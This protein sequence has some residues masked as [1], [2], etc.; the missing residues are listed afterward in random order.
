MDNITLNTIIKKFDIE[1]IEKHIIYLYLLAN[2]IDYKSNKF[3]TSYF[4]GFIVSEEIQTDIQ[5]LN[6][7][8]LEELAVDMEL[9]IPNNDRVVNGA[10]FTP[11][12]IVDYIIET[13]APKKNAK[14]AD[15]SCGS[16]AFLLGIVRYF[17][18][19]YH[20]KIS[21]I[22]KDNLYGV[23]I[24]QYNVQRSKLLLTLIALQD[25]ENIDENL[26]NVV[27]ADS[28]KKKWDLSFDAIVGNPPYVK[29][30]DLTDETREYLSH[31]WSTTTFGTYNL[32]F[33]F[34]ELGYKL[35]NQNGK[36]GYITPNNYFT[37]L[38]GECLRTFF[39]DKK[40]I[41]QI[42]DFDATKVF[43]VQTY[44]AITFLNKKNNNH[45]EYARI[46]RGQSIN[47]YLRN[48]SF[49]ENKYADLLVKKWRLLCNDERVNINQIENAGLTIGT[50][51]N[52]CVGIA[53]LKDDIYFIDPIG[54][55]DNNYKIKK[56]NKEYLIEKG[57]TRPLVKISEMKKQEDVSN[58][59]RRIIFPY[60][61]EK[62]KSIVLT[63]DEIKKCYP[64]C[65]QYLVSVRN[66]LEMRGKGKHN[67]T[68]F[69][70]YGRSQG[71]NRYG[72][73]LLTPTFSKYPRFLLDK[74]EEGFFTNGY[75]IYFRPQQKNLFDVTNPIA[76]INNIDVLLKI[77]NS[78]IMHY[79]VVKTSVAIEGGFPC[80]QKN[81]IE[82]F[83][84]PTFTNEEIENLRCINDKNEIDEYLINK[85]HLNLSLPNL[86]E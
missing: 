15:I 28:L 43:D 36:L 65:Y 73:K 84:I 10:F 86:S 60:R 76:E 81:F 67:Y 40:C 78:Y 50:L 6:H 68:P 4:N 31:N 35:L 26:I 19:K 82:K 27:C 48:A 61:V 8:T 56:G 11:S 20:K 70:V 49:T 64:N 30:Q 55:E 7:F 44:T 38:S 1:S 66:I 25:R 53:T 80:Y 39:Q 23:D 83:S 17:K 9:L 75:G 59:V 24:L 42:T 41:Y 45:I 62:G 5:K 71:L 37:S 85:Y 12:N 57:A 16:G 22:I 69:Y 72:I 46:E 14:V 79:Y 2:N 74:N 3:L 52:I 77:L 34:F 47:D 21:S 54:E 58:N 29:F 32:Y 18:N 51:F 63:E 33:A 13:I